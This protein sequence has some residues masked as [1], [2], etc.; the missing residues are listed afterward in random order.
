[1]TY[2][3]VALAGG[4]GGARLAHGLYQTLLKGDLTVIVN[5]GDDFTFNG[6]NIS[7]DI[8]TICYILAGIANPETG[9]GIKDD[10]HQAL[11]QIRNLGGDDWFSLGDRDIG[12]H[13]T[14]TQALTNGISL[15]EITK[16]FC[17]NMGITA[18]VIPMADE[19]VH[20]KVQIEGGTW[21]DFQ[22][23][24][25][26]QKCQPK[27]TAFKFNGIERA[28]PAPGVLKAIKEA[29]LMVICPSNPW[30]SIDPILAVHQIRLAVSDK[31]MVAVSPLIGGQ[32]IKGPL[33]KMYTELGM[34]PSCLTIASHYQDLLTGFV[35]DQADHAETG[36]IEAF[37]IITK[38]TDILMKN[39][40][41]RKR[42]ADE[43]LVFGKTLIKSK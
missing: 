18:H 40:K 5:T 38:I 17:L 6:L 27:V 34:T 22:E 31:C 12:T 11:D 3:V 2:K 23:Y 25:V 39:T 7:P 14:R 9:W 30:V 26:H 15:S 37:G 4:V 8:D 28:R 21:L 24:F 35:I 32:A 20:T 41:D 29:D 42:L 43:I 13:L 33:A 1:M 19:P 16:Q 10:T 36:P